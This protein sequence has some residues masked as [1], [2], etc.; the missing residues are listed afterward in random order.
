MAGYT[1]PTKFYE[2]GRV[3]R[4]RLDPEYLPSQNNGYERYAEM[5]RMYGCDP[6]NMKDINDGRV[7]WSVQELSS[8]DAASPYPVRGAAKKSPLSTHDPMPAMPGAE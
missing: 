2:F 4:S 8:Q 3:E 1:K 5:A 6:M 7:D